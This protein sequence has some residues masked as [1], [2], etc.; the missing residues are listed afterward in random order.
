[1]ALFRRKPSSPVRSN[2]RRRRRMLAD[3]LVQEL[4]P[5][6]LLTVTGEFVGDILTLTG[7]GSNSVELSLSPTDELGYSTDG[8]LTYN[9][10]FLDVTD[11]TLPVP[12]PFVFTPASV[13]DISLGLGTESLTLNSTLTDALRFGGLVADTG[14]GLP[15]DNTLQGSNNGAPWTIIGPD[16]GTLGGINVQFDDVGNLVGGTGADSFDFSPSGSLAGSIDGGGGGDTIKWSAMTPRNVT[17]TGASGSGFAGSEASIAGGFSQIDDLAGSTG[18][19]LTGLP[20]A[21]STWAVNASGT[22][23]YSTGTDTLTF[24]GFANLD[25]GGGDTFDFGNGAVVSGSI[26]GGGNSTLN[27]SADSTPRNVTL[28]GVG[29]GGFS[30]RDASIGGGFTVIGTL[31]GPAS[32]GSSLTGLDAAAAW[33]LLATGADTYTSTDT[34]TFSGFT[35]LVGGTVADTFDIAGTQPV[36]LQ[37]G[38]GTADFIFAKGRA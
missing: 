37:G 20:R 12:A 36:S 17:L 3:R 38:G 8:G 23:T 2:S 22:D 18:S 25:G 11:P 31:V 9:Y 33:D 30:G 32:A 34:L 15:S 21:S 35:D 14:E 10:E 7:L 4:E 5:R 26:T 1:M 13:M 16:S 29:S 28:T 6:V 24:S 19:T 27:W